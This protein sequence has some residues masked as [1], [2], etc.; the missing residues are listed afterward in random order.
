MTNFMGQRVGR[1]IPMTTAFL[2]AATMA[3]RGHIAYRD[4]LDE[5]GDYAADRAADEKYG[6]NAWLIYGAAAWGVS[7]VDYW[8][9]PRIELIETT[10]TRLTLGVPKATRVGAMWRSILVPGAGQEYGNHRT[11][12]IVWLSSVL[13]AGAGYVVTDYRVRRDET[14]L[15]FAQ[16]NADSAGPSEQVQRQEELEQAERSLEASKDVRTGF[17][18]GIAAFHALNIFDSMVMYLN[19]PAPEKPKV[20]SI[21][22]IMLPD[23]PGIGVDFRF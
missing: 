18:I 11:R 10:P 7:A 2:G 19:L 20:S 14:D 12:S 17:L 6:R 21:S 3:V 16:I 15:K 13:G 4:R 9:R 5:V 8:V 1:G 22:P 23:G